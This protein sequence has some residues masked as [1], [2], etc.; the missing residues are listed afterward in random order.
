MAERGS[1]PWSVSDELWLLIEPLTPVPA[2]E[3]VAGRPWVP[4]RRALSVLH[5]GV[6]W[7]RLP[8][9]LGFVSGMT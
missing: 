7:E 5:A 1:R 9:E 2:P 3:P 4:D 6:Q 8:Q